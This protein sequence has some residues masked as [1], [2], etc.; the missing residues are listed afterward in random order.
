MG[1]VGPLLPSSLNIYNSE[2]KFLVPH[3]NPSCILWRK[4]NSSYTEMS[5]HLSVK[6]WTRSKAV[7]GNS[8]TH[9]RHIIKKERQDRFAQKEIYQSIPLL[10]IKSSFFWV[11]VYSLPTPYPHL[12]KEVFW[13]SHPTHYQRHPKEKCLGEQSYANANETLLT[14]QP[15]SLFINMNQQQSQQTCKEKKL[16][17]RNVNIN[18]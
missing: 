3:K 9:N 2:Q 16:H 4:N 12:I 14:S 17:M 15:R 8:E 11:I 1:L 18:K 7:W 10:R 13:L 6:P 5:P